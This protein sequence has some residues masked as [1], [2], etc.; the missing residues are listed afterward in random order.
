[1]PSDQEDI[2]QLQQEVARLGRLVDELYVR[3][4]GIAPDG[5]V[6]P[7]NPPADVIAALEAG[8]PIEAIKRWRTHTGSGLAE[9]KDQVEAIARQRGL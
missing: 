3:L 9:A 7:A 1:M 8:S 5:V 2:A 6:D 4:D